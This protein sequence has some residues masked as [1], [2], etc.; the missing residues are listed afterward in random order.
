MN[1]VIENQDRSSLVVWNGKF[2]DITLNAGGAVIYPAGKVLAFDGPAGKYKITE[3]GT[4]AVANSKAV[5]VQE[6][7]FTGAGDKLVRAVIGGRVDSSLL[8]FD[9]ADTLDTIPATGD[10]TFR[11]QLRSYGIVAED[12]SEQYIQDNQ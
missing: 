9:G 11:I 1:P 4:A 5:L 12:L 7:E 8:I 10:E 3:S 6:T 2:K